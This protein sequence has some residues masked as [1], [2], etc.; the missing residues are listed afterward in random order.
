MK[1]KYIANDISMTSAFL[2]SRNSGRIGG[3]P[4]RLGKGNHVK[5][6]HASVKRTVNNEQVESED[7]FLCMSRR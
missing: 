5:E 4:F 1:A 6:G 7:Y 3:C 2:D